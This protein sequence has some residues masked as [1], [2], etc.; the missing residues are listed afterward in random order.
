DYFNGKGTGLNSSLAYR[1]QPYG[2]FTIDANFTAI[3]LPKPYNSVR[4]LLIGPRAE[5][6]FSRSVF[7]STFFQYNTQT[8]NTNIN[9]RLQWRFRPVSDLFLVYT[10][11]YFAQPIA[12]FQVPAWAPKNRALILKFTY[13]LNV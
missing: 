1:V 2:T 5:L 4:Y 7:L 10:D 8:N 12:H 3:D 9:T 11:N 13:W 6:T